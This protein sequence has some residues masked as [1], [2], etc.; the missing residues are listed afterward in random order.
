M[1][2]VFKFQIVNLGSS[3]QQLNESSSFINRP[4]L[5]VN[6]DVKKWGDEYIL[7]TNTS[8]R[9][10]E[11]QEG[12]KFVGSFALDRSIKKFLKLFKEIDIP[13]DDID[14]YIV[15]IDKHT[16]T[17]IHK[18]NH[19]I[20]SNYSSYSCVLSCAYNNTPKGIDNQLILVCQDGDR[21]K[22]DGNLFEFNDEI[23]EFVL[24]E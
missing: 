21:I 20:K 14:Y 6:E 23:L 1:E 8:N 19:F 12:L 13:I 11:N 2:N 16:E 15:T 9:F 5:N 3:M 18:I 4:M 7:I 10:L 24:V 22:L 17:K